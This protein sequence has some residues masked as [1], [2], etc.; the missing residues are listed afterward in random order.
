MFR[1]LIFTGLLTLPFITAAQSDDAAYRNFLIDLNTAIHSKDTSLLFPMLGDFI[2]EGPSGCDYGTKRCFIESMAFKEL[3][4]ESQFWLQSSL[5]VNI[6]LKKQVAS[7]KVELPFLQPG[8]IYYIGPTF[9][10]TIPVGYSVIIME[11][12]KVYQKPSVKSKV[13][14]ELAKFNLVQSNPSNE[15]SDWPNLG[16][17]VNDEFWIEIKLKGGKIGYVKQANTSDE[18]VR[19]IIISKV[20]NSWKITGFYDL[21]VE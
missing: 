21:S 4:N 3:G 1:G 8:Q 2:Y 14:A 16:G 11:N 19:T 6:G 13:I 10:N 12:T 17:F 7:R 5:I 9:D 15:L 18:L 20:K